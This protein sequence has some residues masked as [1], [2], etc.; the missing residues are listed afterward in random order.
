[1]LKLMHGRAIDERASVQDDRKKPDS[2]AL[3]HAALGDVSVALR[4]LN[5]R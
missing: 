2:E 3:P 1:M 4:A 5:Y